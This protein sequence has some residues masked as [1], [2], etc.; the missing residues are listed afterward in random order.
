MN[1]IE[2]VYKNLLLHSNSA[3]HK[4]LSLFS[5]SAGDILLLNDLFHHHEEERF[6]ELIDVCIDYVLE[7]AEGI[8]DL[9]FSS[10]LCGV[11]YSLLSVKD[12]VDVD[13]PDIEDLDSVVWGQVNHTFR[14]GNYDLQ[15][16][17]LG[18]G[19]YYLKLSET[20]DKY[21]DRVRDICKMICELF[22]AQRDG[23]ILPYRLETHPLFAKDVQWTNNGF[24]HGVNSVI[25]FL[26]ICIKSGVYDQ[27]II[28]TTLKLLNFEVSLYDEQMVS[29]PMAYMYDSQFDLILD[30]RKT[31]LYYCT[32]DYG[33]ITN[34]LKASELFDNQVFLRAAKCSYKRIIRRLQAGETNKDFCFCHGKATLVYFTER[35]RELSE[36]DT[37]SCDREI[38]E[39]TNSLT[40]TT[41]DASVL[42]GDNGIN[43]ALLSKHMI[44]SLERV[45]LLQ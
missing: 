8:D 11:L 39:I 3:P 18:Y 43:M 33:I 24:L 10:G 29:Y 19:L 42:N 13:L 9:S 4:N 36:K 44:C 38:I 20:N 30:K 22:V 41:G 40:T 37:Y 45:L 1:E 31:G 34:Y 23:I 5:G 27:R 32:G 2:T 6:R 14:S 15:S 17:L 35:L 28:E 16:G 12:T 21:I 25:A 7:G 26:L